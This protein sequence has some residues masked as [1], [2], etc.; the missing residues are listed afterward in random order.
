MSHTGGATSWLRSGTKRASD[1]K[2]KPRSRSRSPDPLGRRSL[3]PPLPLDYCQ[4]RDQIAELTEQC[5]EWRN[6]WCA[7]DKENEKLEEE[8]ENLKARLEEFE[9]KRVAE[10]AE[11]CMGYEDDW[12]RLNEEKETLAARLK[13]LEA[14]LRVEDAM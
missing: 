13:E 8:N 4:L 2:S 11:H 7:S 6:D 14:K 3:T 9:K 5:K 1:W 12:H 10:L